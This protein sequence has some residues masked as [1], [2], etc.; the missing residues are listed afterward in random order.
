MG[1]IFVKFRYK[2]WVGNLFLMCSIASQINLIGFYL[3]D[4]ALYITDGWGVVS[5]LSWY[6]ITTGWFVAPDITKICQYQPTMSSPGTSASKA[7]RTEIK[8]FHCPTYLLLNSA[9]F[10]LEKI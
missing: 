5:S 7:S 1:K 9:I 3:S 8:P 2:G 10:S 6:S 4:M